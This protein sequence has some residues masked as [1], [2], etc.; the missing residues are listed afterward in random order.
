MARCNGYVCC[1]NLTMFCQLH[2][3]I[4]LNDRITVED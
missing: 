3:Y 1:V 2:G 4:A